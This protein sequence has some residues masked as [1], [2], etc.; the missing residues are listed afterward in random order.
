MDYSF[1]GDC[2][3]GVAPFSNGLS[4]HQE[5]SGDTISKLNWTYAIYSFWTD[6]FCLFRRELAQ[7]TWTLSS[8]SL[9]KEKQEPFIL[10][11]NLTKMK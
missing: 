2:L 7:E 4:G 5:E 3:K 9:T 6:F 8:I 10:D 11:R 1:K